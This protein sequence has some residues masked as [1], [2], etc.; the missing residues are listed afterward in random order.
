VSEYEINSVQFSDDG[1]AIQYMEV[2]DDIRVKGMVVRTSYLTVSAA[3]PD[4]REDIAL[5]HGRA[6]KVLRNVLEDFNDSEPYVPEK[7]PDED[8]DGGMGE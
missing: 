6:V 1:V 8:E 4:Y 7:E 3:H 5:L 2:P